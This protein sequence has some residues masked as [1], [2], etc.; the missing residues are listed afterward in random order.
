MANEQNLIPFNQRSESEQREMRRKGGINSGKSRLKKKYGQEL[1]RM[2]L[3]MPEKDPR[4]IEELTRLGINPKDMKKEVAMNA[5]QIDKAIRKADTSAYMAV[6][7]A[8]GY[9]KGEGVNIRIGSDEKPPVI[10]FGTAGEQ[11]EQHDEPAPEQEP[12]MM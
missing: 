10:V 5:R 3:D 8:A 1:V 2:M 9:D 12:E 4:I 11:E 6:L 7:K